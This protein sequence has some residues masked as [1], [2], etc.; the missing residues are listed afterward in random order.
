MYLPIIYDGIGWPVVRI[1]VRC[2]SARLH[3]QLCVVERR[4]GIYLHVNLVSHIKLQRVG[5]RI[6]HGFKVVRVEELKL[7]GESTKAFLLDCD[8]FPVCSETQGHVAPLGVLAAELDLRQ[9]SPGDDV[10]G[11]VYGGDFVLEEEVVVILLQMG[12]VIYL[13]SPKGNN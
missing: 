10:M 11:V 2:S 4:C 5:R 7:V 6:N 9:V 1:I 3:K 12:K 13:S 8:T